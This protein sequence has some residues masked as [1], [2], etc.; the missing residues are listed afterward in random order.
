VAQAAKEIDFTEQQLQMQEWAKAIADGAN[1]MSDIFTIESGIL[2][3]QLDANLLTQEEYSASHEALVMQNIANERAML[4]DAA[5]QGLL[6]DEE[7]AQARYA[8]EMKAQK[9]QLDLT[10]AR[11]KSEEALNKTREQNFKST[12][13]T[14][15]SLAGSSNKELAAIGKAAAVTQATIDGYAAVQKALA[16]AP[17]PFNFALAAAVGIATA[18][19]IAK[20]AGTPLQS[21]I[22]SVPGTGFRDNFPAVLAPGER[23]VP[24]KTNE[25]LTEALEG[26][27][28]G[29]QT[30]NVTV[31][32][33]DIFTSDPREMGLKIIETIND[34]AQANGIQ[35]LGNQ[36]R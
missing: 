16:S 28:L 5:A 4:D 17:P 36:I 35:V 15:S 10:A 27:G 8:L 18:G 21:G 30:I 23:V 19:N 7:V 25:D 13:G 9:D 31:N 29:G 11:I 32:M 6:T 20:I 12:L 1:S 22:D 24:R 33:S 3:A 26:G 34:A 2:K 14:I